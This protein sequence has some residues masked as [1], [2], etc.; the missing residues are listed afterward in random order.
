VK[1]VQIN[2]NELT[3]GGF[4]IDADAEAASRYL[5]GVGPTNGAMKIAEFHPILLGP[6][7]RAALGTFP[8]HLTTLPVAGTMAAARPWFGY[9]FRD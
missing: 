2:E 4:L 1:R 5:P 7:G 8:R 9:R 3:W 6:T